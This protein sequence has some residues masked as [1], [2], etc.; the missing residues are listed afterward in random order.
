M[1]WIINGGELRVIAVRTLPV[2]VTSANCSVAGSSPEFLLGSTIQAMRYV[3]SQLIRLFVGLS[4]HTQTL[5]P[6]CR[7]SRRC[8]RRP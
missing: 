8:N 2:F 1:A 7:T 3:T 4:A 5:F 6:C